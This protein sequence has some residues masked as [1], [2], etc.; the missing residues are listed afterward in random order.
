MTEEDDNKMVHFSLSVRGMS[1]AKRWFNAF[2]EI[3]IDVHK[4]EC[5]RIFLRRD[6]VERYVKTRES[7]WNHLVIGVPFE[8]RFFDVITHIA[9]LEKDEY[10]SEH[11]EHKIGLNPEEQLEVLIKLE[12]LGLLQSGED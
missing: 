9:M 1:L 8:A 6:Q 12:E 11:M 7:I 5:G 10:R 4:D 2:D 3:V